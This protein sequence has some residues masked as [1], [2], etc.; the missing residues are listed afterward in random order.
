MF[1][2]TPFVSLFLALTPF[3]P[4]L[5]QYLTGTSFVK[6]WCDRFHVLPTILVFGVLT[7][8]Y[9][10]ALSTTSAMF[11]SLFRDVVPMSHMGRFLALF[12][13]VGALAT[14]AITYWLVGLA[15]THAKHIFVSLAVLNLTG[16][17][18]L[19]LRVKEAECPVLEEEPRSGGLDFLLR[20]IAVQAFGRH[21]V[22][23]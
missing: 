22:K 3:A 20:E 10:I 5:G 21:T 6:D 13:I 15:E 19:C 18:V 12:R 4:E 14:F 2:A 11:F 8:G 23:G 17:F 1:W 9:R 16:F 7:V